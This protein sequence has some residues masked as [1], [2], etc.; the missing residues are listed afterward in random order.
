[1]SLT[2]VDMTDTRNWLER[3]SIPP[4]KLRREEY[5]AKLAMSLRDALEALSTEEFS[6]WMK[7]AN[8]SAQ[9]I[10]EMLSFLDLDTRRVKYVNDG[11]I[12]F[13]KSLKPTTI[14]SGTK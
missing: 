11:T 3:F 8:Y 6:D 2:P 12:K 9:D 5:Y 1:M 13:L 7:Y 14:W 10:S 4:G